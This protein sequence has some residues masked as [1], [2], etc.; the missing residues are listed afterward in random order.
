[1]KFEEKNNIII[2]TQ[3]S[4]FLVHNKNNDFIKSSEIKW[5]RKNFQM[6]RNP[7]IFD[8]ENIKI[9]D[10]NNSNIKN[11]F[12]DNDSLILPNR[13]FGYN[14]QNILMHF[15][16]DKISDLQSNFMEFFKKTNLYLSYKESKK[17]QNNSGKKIIENIKET[18][19]NPRSIENCFIVEYNKKIF[20]A[21][22]LIDD[23]DKKISEIKPEEKNSDINIYK[24]LKNILMNYCL[25]LGINNNNNNNN[26]IKQSKFSYMSN[27][28]I[29]EKLND[30]NNSI[31][32]NLTKTKIKQ[33]KNQ[34][35]KGHIKSNNSLL[36][37]SINQS[38]NFNLIGIDKSS[39]DYFK[40]YKKDGFLNF[41][42]NI[43]QLNKSLCDIHR[44]EIFKELLNKYKTLENIFKDQ[45]EEEQNEVI[46]DVLNDNFEEEEENDDD[47]NDNKENGNGIL[48]KNG[49]KKKDKKQLLLEEIQSSV[50][51]YNCNKKLTQID[52]NEEENINN[53]DSFTEKEKEKNLHKNSI[54]IKE[55]NNNE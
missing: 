4:Q 40:F 27:N 34:N 42:K 18:I 43:N 19:F 6:I 11:Y 7:E 17:Y 32:L 16:L 50:I 55:G 28:N 10:K 24:D 20:S 9:K 25:V 39:K 51:L 3:N 44:M 36:Q 53:N 49:F 13:S 5:L 30:F 48:L 22:S 37:F 33:N 31:N 8:I 46:I 21:L 1:M 15:Y 54:D 26:S 45:A 23:I 47:N 14:I 52:E 2:D 12:N 41:V 38:T 29:E 35:K